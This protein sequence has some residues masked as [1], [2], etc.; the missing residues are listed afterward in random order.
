VRPTVTVAI[1]TRNRHESLRRAVA[2]VV[3]A[4]PDVEE[5]LIIDQSDEFIPLERPWTRGFRH[6]R[7]ESRGLSRARNEALALATTEIVFFTDDDCLLQPG[8]VEAAVAMF[9][10]QPE[11]GL[12]FGAVR[13][14]ESVTENGIISTFEPKRFRIH[15]GRIASAFLGGMGACMAVRREIAL[16]AGGFHVM[17]GVGAKLPGGEDCEFAYRV[18]K[19]HQKV[20]VEPRCVVIHE[21]V[22]SWCA[23]SDHFYEGYLAIG[24]GFGLH[25]RDGDLLALFPV[26]KHMLILLCTIIR[27]IYNGQY[28]RTGIRRMIALL[29]GVSVGLTVP[30]SGMMSRTNGV[31][32]VGHG[33][34]GRRALRRTGV[35]EATTTRR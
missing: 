8:A 27:A 31:L 19:Y 25:I 29:I 24:A 6:V 30:R 23:L 26:A 1:C 21:G 3:A 32:S 14:K 13:A 2:A 9:A 20:A 18:L 11:V 16:A 35:G 4:D 22:K 7:S 10:E 15:R 5:L 34:R 33:Q 28:K 12:V 17:L